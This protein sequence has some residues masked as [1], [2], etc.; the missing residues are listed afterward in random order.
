MEGK[1]LGL[2]REV[3]PNTPLIGVLLNPASVSNFKRELSDVQEVARAVGQQL[4]YPAR[5]QRRGDRLRLCYSGRATTWRAA[6]CCRP[7]LDGPPRTYVALAA[8]YAIPAI[9]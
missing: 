2:L 8:R 6:R 9:Y 5:Q 3:V 4:S 7:I 1:R